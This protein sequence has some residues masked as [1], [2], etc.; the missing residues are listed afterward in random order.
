MVDEP[1]NPVAEISEQE[2]EQLRFVGMDKVVGVF[3]DAFLLA[4]KEDAFNIFIFQNQLEDFLGNLGESTKMGSTETKCVARIV[5]T[6]TGLS[7]LFE[8][9]ALNLG[10]QLVPQDPELESETDK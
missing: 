6:P 7:K 3:C 9:I 8:A 2:K 5:L 10:I 1:E 4:R